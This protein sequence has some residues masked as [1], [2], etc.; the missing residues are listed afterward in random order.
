MIVGI[1]LANTIAGAPVKKGRHSK[2]VSHPEKT[3][4]KV[5]YLIY[6]LH[7]IHFLFTLHQPQKEDEDALQKE[8]ASI[9]NRI[10]KKLHIKKEDSNGN[11]SNEESKSPEIRRH[12]ERDESRNRIASQEEEDDMRMYD[13]SDDDEEIKYVPSMPDIYLNITYIYIYITK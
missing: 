9:L 2:K 8:K 1:A 11:G 13:A 10:K 4:P 12:S 5:F 3:S 6:I 7:I